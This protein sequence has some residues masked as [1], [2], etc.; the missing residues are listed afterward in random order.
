MN[1]MSSYVFGKVKEQGC[2]SEN[3]SQSAN[4]SVP[5]GRQGNEAIAKG[6]EPRNRSNLK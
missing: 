4:A 2:L 3:I 6:H 5:I 1:W